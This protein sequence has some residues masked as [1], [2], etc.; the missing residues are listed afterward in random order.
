MF[1]YIHIGMSKKV[2]LEKAVVTGCLRWGWLPKLA[3]AGAYSARGLCTQVS[4]HGPY[5]F[6]DGQ[7]ARNF[8]KCPVGSSGAVVSAVGNV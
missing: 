5:F 3:W 4:Q 8:N 2:E 1:V 6:S 7:Q